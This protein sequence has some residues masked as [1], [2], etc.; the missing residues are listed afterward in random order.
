MRKLLFLLLA[1]PALLAA[2]TNGALLHITPANPKPGEQIRVEYDLPK[3]PLKTANAL[4]IVAFDYTDKNPEAREVSLQTVDNKLVGTFTTA[5]GALTATIAFKGD[6]RWDNNGGEGYFITLYD[7][8]GKPLAESKAAQAI[9]YRNF[10]ALEN[11]AGKPNVANEW[12]DAAFKAN[13]SI[14]QKYLGVY[15][16]N[17]M[18]YKKDDAGKMEATKLIEELVASPKATEKDLLNGIRLYE[19]LQQM[20]KAKAVKETMKTA[21]PKG[22]LYQQER[23]AT[24]ANQPDLPTREKLISQFV[25]DFPPQNDADQAAID[26]MWSTM[27]SRYAELNDLEKFRE[28]TLHMS[29]VARASL[30]NNMAWELAEKDENLGWADIL[31]KQAANGTKLEIS[32]PSTT[33]PPSMTVKEWEKSRKYTFAQYADTY[34]YVLDKLGKSQD[35]IDYQAQVVEIME[36]SEDEMNERYTAYLEKTNAP[37]LRSQ[38]EGFILKGHATGTMKEQFQRLYL[39]G[40]N[41]AAGATAY[42]ANLEKSAKIR[43]SKELATQMLD[44]AA[45][46][47][48]L[49]NLKGE[50]VSL[51]GLKGKVVIV[52]FWATWC[53]PC[54]ASFP[55][56]QLAQEQ[57]KNEPNVVFLFVDTWERVPTAEK[58]KTAGDF[59]TEKKYP[60][61]VLLDL[62]NQVVSSFGVSGIP[63]KFIIDKTGKIR[64]KAVGYQGTPE[65]LVEELGM[66]V[67]LVKG[68]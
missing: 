51:A 61:N 60:F 15:T 5:P 38:L 59:M 42:M 58:A 13:P 43:K 35:A 3:S 40:D 44:E 41:S 20:D 46:A 52:D 33:K 31:A 63:T 45:P 49:T 4:E 27:A 55:G 57:Y 53:G 54:K 65:A 8:A 34:A 50:T 29:P 14:R 21:F 16:S 17:L 9:I 22:M 39:A 26:N 2:Q 11:L 24:A 12:L 47:F 66:M 23:R 6:Q 48:T 30:Y 7:A 32:A 62:D 64:F 37:E 68:I 19:F 36:G 67:E 28:I 1:L 10:A 25:K 18:N 56:M